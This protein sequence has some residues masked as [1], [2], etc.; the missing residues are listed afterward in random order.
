MTEH[1]LGSK[2]AH[3][4]PTDIALLDKMSEDSDGADGVAQAQPLVP[5]V[6]QLLPAALIKKLVQRDVISDEKR[7][8]FNSDFLYPDG[9]SEEYKCPNCAL[10]VRHWNCI[11][12]PD[13][14]DDD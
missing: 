11:E 6:V 2:P 7:E 10:G 12:D 8:L 1:F 5:L 13:S 14:S 4:D 9:P 3:E